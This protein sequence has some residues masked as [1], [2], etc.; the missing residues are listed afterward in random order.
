MAP[1]TSVLRKTLC[2]PG[3]I[4]IVRERFSELSDR[5][6]AGSVRFSLTDTLV[7]ALA[8]FQLKSPSLL[9]FDERTRGAEDKTLIGNLRRLYHLLA[10]LSDTQMRSILDA[11]PFTALRPALRAV[12]SAVQRGRMLENF[13][14]EPFGE[15][16]LLAVDGTGLFSS[17]AI[18]CPQCGVKRRANAVK[19]YCH[20]LLVAAIISPET[21]TVLPVDFEPIIASDGQ[22]KDCSERNAARGLIR[23]IAAQYPKRRFLVLEDALSA[24]GPHVRL[25]LEHGMDFIISAKESVLER[26]Y[27]SYDERQSDAAD[28]GVVT[29]ERTD[30]RGVIRGVRFAND[31]PLNAA[32]EELRVNLLELWEVSP[33]TKRMAEKTSTWA[34]ITSLEISETN[35]L[36][37]A[38]AGRTRWRIENE[39]FNC[40][41]NQGYHLEHS[42]G[43]GKEHLSSTLAGLM[44]LSFLFDQVQEHACDLFKR[45][46]QV[47]RRRDELCKN[48]SVLKGDPLQDVVEDR[49]GA[50]GNR[51]T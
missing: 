32:H 27:K 38:R 46:R 45:A 20:E 28:G 25:L 42:Y 36:D 5:R 6:R 4:R 15:R 40:L 3:L 14:L 21:S 49:W 18:R 10:V 31:L 29:F 11:V 1:S 26:L 12:H 19:E 34:W 41:K 47:K 39:T 48:L 13:K 43:H 16:L 51:E 7:S 22:T 50:E 24:N 9:E 35:A 8:M 30:K 23:S 17:T 44:L 2:T 33:A 37:I